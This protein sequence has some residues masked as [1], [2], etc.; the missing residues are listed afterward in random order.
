MSK[1]FRYALQPVLLSRTW[2]LDA[3]KLELGE[4]N[5]SLG[6]LQEQRAALGQESAA[7]N[8]AWQRQAEVPGNFNV[9][10]FATVIAYLGQLA[11][12]ARRKDEEIAL[13][14]QERDALI[15]RIVAEQ[16][17]VEA[18]EEHR[19]KMFAEF[20]KEENSAQFKAADDHWSTLH[21]RDHEHGAD[22]H[23]QQF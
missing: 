5:A 4:R 18:V 17:G 6:E 21:V 20:R 8:Q 13:A 10:G 23:E 19:D 16:R 12:L 3:L 7:V 22:K 14:A 1:R 11:E 9:D 2:A 15:D